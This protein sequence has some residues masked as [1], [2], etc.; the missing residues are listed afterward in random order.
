MNLGNSQGQNFDASGDPRSAAWWKSLSSALL[1]RDGGEE[2]PVWP[3]EILAMRDQVESIAKRAGAY[4]S[5]E[6]LAVIEARC[7]SIESRLDRIE[8]RLERLDT[9]R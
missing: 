5:A 1:A 2:D 3:D 8:R 6:A 4:L 9:S 7:E